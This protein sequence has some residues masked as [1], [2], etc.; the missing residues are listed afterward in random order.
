MNKP[1]SNLHT[2]FIYLALELETGD[3]MMS[4]YY[5]QKYMRTV[6][7][8]ARQ[9]AAV[10]RVAG[11]TPARNNSLC[12]PLSIVPGLEARGN[13]RLLLTNN[14]PV[15]TPAIRA[16]APPRKFEIPKNP[17]HL[18]HD[19]R[20]MKSEES[21]KHFS[22]LGETRENFDFL[23][24]FLFM[25]ND[26]TVGA[27]AGQL[28]TAQRVAGSIPARGNSLCDAQIIVSGL[29][30]I[31]FSC[32]VGAFTNIQVHMHMTPRPETT[33]CGSHKELLPA[34]IEFATPCAGS[35]LPSHRANHA[36][37]SYNIH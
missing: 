1:Q 24:P 12:D 28:A 31:I 4:P 19:S 6:G 25:Y 15:P 14:H 5:L 3:Y 26:C 22:V 21:S 33:I 29:G 32:I 2:S 37:N 18:L 16:G 30:V 7:A 36:V 23:G 13:V 35:Q 20:M 17:K 11:S 8:V 27:V 34:G 9:L 10:Q